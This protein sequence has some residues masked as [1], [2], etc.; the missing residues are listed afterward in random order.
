MVGGRPVQLTA[1]VTLD[2]RISLSPSLSFSLSLS[3]Y[4]YIYMYKVG[5]ETNNLFSSR[6]V[7]SLDPKTT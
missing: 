4:I 1:Q 3:I 7:T 2:R 6:I 5:G